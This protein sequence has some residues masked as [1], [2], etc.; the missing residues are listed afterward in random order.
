MAESG[1]RPDR[2]GPAGMVLRPGRPA[3]TDAVAAMHERCSPAT[4]FAR[5]HA[6]TRTMP[7]QFLHRLLTPPRGR[8]IVAQLGL[9]VVALSQVVDTNEPNTA[10]ISLL[11]ED[12]WQKRGVGAAMLAHLARAARTSGR[13]ELVAWCLADEHQMMRTAARAGLLA[14][15]RYEGTM[16]RLTLDPNGSKSGM[17]PASP[18]DVSGRGLGSAAS[19]APHLSTPKRTR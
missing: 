5:Y 3:D 14:D 11:V 1:R 12:R 18:A 19:G 7:R 17:S 10:E 2:I 8:A 9:H 15:V 16:M 13:T 4:L 6:G